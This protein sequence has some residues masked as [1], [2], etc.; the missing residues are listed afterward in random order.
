MLTL[1]QL[2]QFV[3]LWDYKLVLRV[4]LKEVIAC[5]DLLDLLG[6]VGELL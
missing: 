2:L 4:D 3:S 6:H 5:H 1:R